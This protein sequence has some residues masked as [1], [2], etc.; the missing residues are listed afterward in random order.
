M[1]SFALCTLLALPTADMHPVGTPK[2]PPGFDIEKMS[3]KKAAAEAADWIEKSTPR[4]R[5][6]RRACWSRSSAA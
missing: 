2:L 5:P 6:K 3:D 1:F 4:S